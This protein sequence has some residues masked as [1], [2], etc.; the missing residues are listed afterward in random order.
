EKYLCRKTVFI[1]GG[2]SIAGTLVSSYMTLYRG[3]VTGELSEKTSQLFHKSFTLFTACTI[4]LACKLY[5]RD[6]PV[7]EHTR[8]II[9]RI[10]STTFG[11]FL[12]EGILRKELLPVYDYLEPHIHSLPACFIYLLVCLAVGIIVVSALKKIPVVKKYI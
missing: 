7:K 9:S 3:T 5:F 4:Y 11:I 12:L 1:L 8:K 6:H 2:M 10:S